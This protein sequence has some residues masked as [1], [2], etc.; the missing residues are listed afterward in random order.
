M[1]RPFNYIGE[2]KRGVCRSWWGARAVGEKAE[3]SAGENYE[4]A[5]CGEADVPTL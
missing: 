1:S 5:K 3:G 2:G 4:H